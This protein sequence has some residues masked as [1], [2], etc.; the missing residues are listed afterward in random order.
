MV[1]VSP[2]KYSL[3]TSFIKCVLKIEGIGSELSPIMFGKLLGCTAK[4]FDLYG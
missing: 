4:V 2:F 3:D 1:N